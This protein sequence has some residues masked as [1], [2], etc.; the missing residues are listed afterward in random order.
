MCIAAGET[1]DN[2]KF[3]SSLERVSLSAA[4]RP[5]R[6]GLTMACVG[7]KKV[8]AM[9]SPSSAT[10]AAVAE[11]ATS[12]IRITLYGAKRPAASPTARSTLVHNSAE[13]RGH[14]F[15]CRTRQDGAGHVQDARNMCLTSEA[16]RW[17]RRGSPHA[18]LARA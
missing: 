13:H 4:A 10:A 3:A 2:S 12:P 15:V 5:R 11:D 7:D 6:S 18:A 17:H 8:E 9:T 14:M 1:R 16:R